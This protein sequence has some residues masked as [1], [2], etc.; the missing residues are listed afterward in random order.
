MISKTNCD[1]TVSPD[2]LAPGFV[3]SVSLPKPS[4]QTL[5]LSFLLGFRAI[6]E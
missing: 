3:V 4:F 5:R 2:N 1:N 6:L